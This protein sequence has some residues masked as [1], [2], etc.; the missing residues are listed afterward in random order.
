MLDTQIAMET[1]V[2]FTISNSVIGYD[3]AE[4]EFHQ[5]VSK[6]KLIKILYNHR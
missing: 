4:S 1:S 3:N 5:I 2:T 6:Y